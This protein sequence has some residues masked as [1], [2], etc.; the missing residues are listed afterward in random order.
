MPYLQ[1]QIFGSICSA[2]HPPPCIHEHGT[3]LRTG[4]SRALLFSPLPWPWRCGRSGRWPDALNKERVAHIPRC[5]S[6]VG[7]LQSG[8][9][10]SFRP[11]ARKGPP[12]LEDRDLTK[13]KPK[14]NQAFQGVVPFAWSNGLL[15]WGWRGIVDPVRI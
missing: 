1:A 2:R 8:P 12:H 10:V 7:T 13:G 15:C 14:G 9:W 6:K 3:R 11:H 4:R 5:S